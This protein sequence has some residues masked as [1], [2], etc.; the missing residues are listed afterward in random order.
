VE[1]AHRWPQGGYEPRPELVIAL[2]WLAS[3]TQQPAALSRARRWNVRGAAASQ[4][5]DRYGN[6]GDDGFASTEARAPVR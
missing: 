2:E 4:C 5:R 1:L 6:S 3:L